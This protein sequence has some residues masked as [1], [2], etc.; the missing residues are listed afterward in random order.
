MFYLNLFP[1]C[2]WQQL[3]EASRA[4][5]RRLEITRV[6]KGKEL[7]LSLIRPTYKK[8]VPSPIGTETSAL[9]PVHNVGKRSKQEKATRRIT[10]EKKQQ[11]TVCYKGDI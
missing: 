9:L 1:L 6:M 2:L 5:A 8:D 11:R 10:T 3:D 4:N 7:S